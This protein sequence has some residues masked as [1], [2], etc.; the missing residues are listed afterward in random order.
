MNT[1][2][3]AICGFFL[4]FGVLGAGI[5]SGCTHQEEESHEENAIKKQ[6]R[7][8]EIIRQDAISTSLSLSGIIVPKQYGVIRSLSQGT[9]EYLVPVG[10]RVAIGTS[11]FRIT[12]QNV[13]NNYFHSLQS[14]E[15]TSLITG[16]RIEQSKIALSGSEARLNLAKKNLESTR[17]RNEQSLE[18]AKHSALV[19]YQSAYSALS[20]ALLH[21]SIGNIEN[22]NYAY[23]DLVTTNVVIVSRANIEFGIAVRSFVN[24]PESSGE[25]TVA[26]DLDTM[27][28]TLSDAKKILDTTALVL[29]NAIPGHQGFMQGDIDAAKVTHSQYQNQINQFIERIIGVRNAYENTRISNDLQFEQAQNQLELAEIEYSNAQISLQSAKN[30]ADLERNVSKSQLNMASYNFSNLSLGSPFSGTVLSHYVSVGQQI[31]PSQ[32]IIELGDLSIV[33]ITID[34]DSEFADSV[35]IGDRAL[36]DGSIEGFVAEISPAGD[37]KSGKVGIVIQSDNNNAALVAGDVAEVKLDLVYAGDNLIVI[38]IK[39]AAIE[40]TGTTVLVARDGVAEKREV[41]LGRVFGNRVTIESG[42]ETGDMLI[43]ANGIFV[44]AGD[45]IQISEE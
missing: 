36:I 42:L 7:V 40:P 2:K 18:S 21:L 22:Y 23:K 6:V 5:L 24:L 29:Q 19:A 1:R 28:G 37:I 39:S 34:I 25:D 10:T 12:D 17:K 30:S 27:Y 3:A 16:Q 31:R 11:L 41:T 13:E 14:F 45:E 32:E 33:E 38:P 26:A 43:L 15:Q 44:A 20:Q 35:K 4:L 9:I 8:Q